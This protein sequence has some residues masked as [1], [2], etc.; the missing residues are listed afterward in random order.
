MVVGT[1]AKRSRLLYS[2]LSIAAFGGSPVDLGMD[3]GPPHRGESLWG[4]LLLSYV[5]V[6]SKTLYSRIPLCMG[7]GL[8]RCWR[9]GA[10]AAC[11]GP[12]L[13]T[14]GPAGCD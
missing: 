6:Q 4:Q 2:A 14:E 12:A 9:E 11:V 1:Q 13:P 5:L 7:R 10:V 3:V 8:C